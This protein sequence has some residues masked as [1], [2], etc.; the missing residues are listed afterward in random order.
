MRPL[1]FAAEH[2]DLEIFTDRQAGKYPA[3]F[4]RVAEP[5]PGPALGTN[6]GHVASEKRQPAASRPQE[7]D[8]G[9][10][11]RGF[12]GAVGADQRTASP[13]PTVSVT[14]LSAKT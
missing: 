14:P 9:L 6:A 12:A 5:Q 11:Q 10:E 2:R 7:A 1:C 13:A 3:A 8:D 4:G